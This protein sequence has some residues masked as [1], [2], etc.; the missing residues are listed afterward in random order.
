[1]EIFNA[2]QALES[3][4]KLTKHIDHNILRDCLTGADINNVIQHM[5][6]EEHKEYITLL[7]EQRD[8]GEKLHFHKTFDITYEKY[9]LEEI[10]KTYHKKFVTCYLKP[11]NTDLRINTLKCLINPD[12][13]KFHFQYDTDTNTNCGTIEYKDIFT[14]VLKGDLIVLGQPLSN[15]SQFVEADSTYTHKWFENHEGF[16]ILIE[17]ASLAIYDKNNIY[18]I[19]YGDNFTDVIKNAIIKNAEHINGKYFDYATNKVV[20]RPRKLSGKVANKVIKNNKI[21]DT[22]PDK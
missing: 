20:K 7:E 12:N 15:H 16:T 21:K 9:I 13:R 4:I 2:Q 17:K 8:L 10:N 19:I 22:N 5:S 6:E 18:N 1:M 11:Y 3:Y 14:S